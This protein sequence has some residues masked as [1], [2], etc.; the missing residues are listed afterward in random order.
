MSMRHAYLVMA[1]ND[2]YVL[3]RLVKMLD[4]EN[5]DIYIHI[6]KKSEYD[7]K[8]VSNLVEKSKLFFVKRIPIYWGDYSQ[9]E[10]EMTLLKESIIGKYDYYHIL[11]GCDLPIKKQEYIQKFF[12][13]HKGKE[14]VHFS[15]EILDDVQKEWVELYFLFQ[16]QIA[17]SKN[18]YLKLFFKLINKILLIFQ[19]LIKVNK[20]NG[21]LKLMKG[22]NW[23]SITHEFAK[24][25][26]SKETLIEENFKF[27]R[28]PDE[29][30]V[31]TIMY[32]SKFIKYNYNLEYNDDYSG[33]MR[34]IDWN[35]GNPYVFS[36]KDIRNLQESDLLFARKFSSYKDKDIIDEVFEK[37]N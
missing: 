27:S 20:V 12:E 31:Q 17:C 15:S 4:H 26:I 34:L 1:H 29:F 23:V 2:F 30:F 22:A 28:S 14:F 18:K 25:I 32:N 9:V 11:S 19:K 21:E 37:Y 16:K 7:V 36:K 6:D 24:Y 5:N 35:R 13:K 3:E 33:C 10:C 8:N